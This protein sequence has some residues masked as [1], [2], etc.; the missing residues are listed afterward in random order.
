MK[1]FI[2]PL[3]IVLSIS[4]NI[5]SK[6]ISQK[7]NKKNIP[8]PLRELI[9]EIVDKA[10]AFDDKNGRKKTIEEL[11]KRNG[12]FVFG[13]VYVVAYDMN[14]VVLAH[15]INSKIIGKKLLNWIDPKG[16]YFRKEIRF[17]AQ[18]KG[19]GWVSYE[20]IDPVIKKNRKKVTFIKKH[21]NAIFGCGFYVD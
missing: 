20:Y 9:I 3:I 16:Q 10:I 19:S 17:I 5:F 13:S 7:I 14:L 8:A 21:G 18:T 1:R 11:N 6:N 4:T 15:P 12:M 2:L